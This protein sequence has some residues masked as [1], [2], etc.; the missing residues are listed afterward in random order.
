MG[1]SALAFN[2]KF[3]EKRCQI[4]IQRILD[5]L[6]II[7]RNLMSGLYTLLLGGCRKKY[8]P[9]YGF[10][11]ST[12]TFVYVLNHYSNQ[13]APTAKS[14]P[15]PGKS[16]FPRGGGGRRAPSPALNSAD[17][18]PDGFSKHLKRASPGKRS[19]GR[20]HSVGDPDSFL[21]DR[22]SDVTVCRGGAGM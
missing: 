21:G 2:V 20:L 18:T 15:G 14:P 3:Q 12:S 9:R 5:K 17:Q 8:T 4:S 10:M 6:W 16:S 19:P 11:A 1:L 13:T 22:F 7:V